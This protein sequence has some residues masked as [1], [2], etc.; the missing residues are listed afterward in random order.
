LYALRRDG[1]IFRSTKFIGKQRRWDGK[2]VQVEGW[3]G[4]D[5]K[6]YSFSEFGGEGKRRSQKRAHATEPRK[7]ARKQRNVAGCLTKAKAVETSEEDLDVL[8]WGG[9][10]DYNVS[11]LKKSKFRGL[12]HNHLL[13]VSYWWK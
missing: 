2:E 12:F 4:Q 7:R 8:A 6:G 10:E 9:K 1:T 13:W 5:S 11:T 3:G